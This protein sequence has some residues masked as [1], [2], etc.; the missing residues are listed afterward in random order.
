MFYWDIKNNE[1]PSSPRPHTF[2]GF[3]SFFLCLKVI[4]PENTRDLYTCLWE[5]ND[6]SY[7]RIKSVRLRKGTHR[8]GMGFA[9]II[10]LSSLIS[11]HPSNHCCAQSLK[12][13]SIK[14]KGSKLQSS[15][16]AG[17][18]GTKAWKQQRTLRQ[19]LW[20]KWRGASVRVDKV[21]EFWVGKNWVGFKA[22]TCMW[23]RKRRKCW[24]QGTAGAEIPR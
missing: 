11:K 21:R 24:F 4:S 2:C 12:K 6:V 17:Y 20:P 8:A 7:H 1:V 10:F 18:W 15:T 9:A 13:A 16:A 19:R 5:F 22:L 3:L 23:R 14:H